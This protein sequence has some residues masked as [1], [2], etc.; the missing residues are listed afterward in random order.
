MKSVSTCGV[1]CNLTNVS[2][3]VQANPTVDRYAGAC[4]VPC[5]IRSKGKNHIGDFFHRR[6][7]TQKDAHSLAI[8][9]EKFG[10]GFAL[11]FPHIFRPNLAGFC[12]NEPRHDDVNRDLVRS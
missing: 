12:A 8:S 1:V 3:G 11:L 6:P 4:E 10:L 2:S 9:R 7:A 5:A